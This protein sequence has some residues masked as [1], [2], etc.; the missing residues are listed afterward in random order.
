MGVKGMDG[1]ICRQVGGRVS[2]KE[3]GW[4]GGR[5]H[6]ALGIGAHFF[7]P[8]PPKPQG[9]QEGDEEEEGPIVDAEA[10]EGDA[11]AS[12]A[13]RKEK[14]EEEVRGLAM[15]KGLWAHPFSVT[16]AR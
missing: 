11:D 2:R 16:P 7:P 1:E 9:E 4:V 15:V 6:Q 5:I 13:K 8:C 10:D 3:D 14:Q 12:D